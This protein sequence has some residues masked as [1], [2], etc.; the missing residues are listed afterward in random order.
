MEEALGFRKLL[1]AAAFAALLVPR[2]LGAHVAPATAREMVEGSPHVVVAVVESRQSRWNPQHTLIRTDYS[3]RIEDRLRGEAPDRISIS[4][5]GGTVG[6]VTDETC[7]T[8][9]LEPGAR[10]LLFLGSLGEPTLSPITGAWHGVFAEKRLGDAGVAF[11]DLVEAVRVLVQDVEASPGAPEP[12][13]KRGLVEL[14]S[15]IYDPAAR[16]VDVSRSRPPQAAPASAPEPPPFRTSRVTLLAGMEEPRLASVKYVPFSE[17]PRA[18]IVINPI[19]PGSPF[20][21]EDQRGMAYWNLY[22]GDLFRIVDTPSVTWAYGNGVFDIAGFPGDEQMRAQFGDTWGDLGTGVLGITYVRFQDGALVEADVALNPNQVWTLDLREGTR[23]GT[24]TPYPFGEV[25]VHELGHV[26]GL[27]HP[28]ETQNVWWDSVMNYKTKAFYLGV[29]YADDTAGARFLHRGV[30]LRD[31]LVSSHLTRH[32]QGN[33]LPEYLP[34]RPTVP[35]VRAGKSFGLSNAVKVENPGT[36]PLARPTVEIYLVPQRFSFEGAVLLKKVRLQGTV[37]PSA[38]QTI[39]P[40][41]LLVP[42][43]TPPG[44]YY[45]AYYLRDPQDAWPANNATW[46]NYD[47][48]ID[49][50]P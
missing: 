29:L 18:P 43:Q 22:A 5:P 14:P 6:N 45:L 28:W 47:V 34:A 3:L 10:Y 31:G 16:P 27:R 25:M 30:P 36:V 19:L 44:T 37:K 1:A 7:L 17:P 20:S 26:L 13:A 42:R 39:K 9:R 38:T 41:K 50:T 49:V 21:S 12:R 2:A 24:G 4:I 48:T 46:S 23:R 15:K 35:A 40:G 33:I 11:A 8:V 32:V